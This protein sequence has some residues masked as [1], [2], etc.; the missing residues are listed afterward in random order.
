VKFLLLFSVVADELLLS[1]KSYW[2]LTVSKL[3]LL[4]LAKL[5]LTAALRN[6]GF[7]Q[8]QLNLWPL[9]ILFK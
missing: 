8:K 3:L 4:I 9:N 5:Y 7:D 2:P 6:I 1:L